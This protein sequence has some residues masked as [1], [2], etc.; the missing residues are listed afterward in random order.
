METARTAGLLLHWEHVPV[1]WPVSPMISWV[2]VVV[3]M[4]SAIVTSA[5]VKTLVA[6]I[7]AVSM[8]PIGMLIA[9]SRPAQS[10][11]LHCLACLRARWRTALAKPAA[12]YRKHN[13]HAS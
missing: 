8:N 12:S 3:L 10:A 5:P 6:G 11:G 2:G 13:R 1:S 7:I 9:R 4:F